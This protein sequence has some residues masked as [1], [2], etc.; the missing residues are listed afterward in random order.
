MTARVNSCP[1]RKPT[2]SKLNLA[3]R[4]SHR[5]FPK[6]RTQ[7]PQNCVDITANRTQYLV[8]VTLLPLEM[9][10]GFRFKGKIVEEEFHASKEKGSEKEKETLVG[11]ERDSR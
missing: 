4:R 3:R 5:P 2:F 8:V 9:G 11:G 7:I 10:N 1:S 6:I